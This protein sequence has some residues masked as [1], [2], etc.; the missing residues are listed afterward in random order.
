[1]EDSDAGRPEGGGAPRRRRRNHPGDSRPDQHVPKSSRGNH[2]G[3]TGRRRSGKHRG[4]KGGHRA[5]HFRDFARP[6][7]PRGMEAA[8]QRRGQA[9]RP[10]G[11]CFQRWRGVGRQGPACDTSPASAAPPLD[12]RPPRWR[13]RVE[14]GH[15]VTTSTDSHDNDCQPASDKREHDGT[16]NP[17]RRTTSTDLTARSRKASHTGTGLCRATAPCRAA[18]C[19]RARAAVLSGRPSVGCA[20]ARRVEASA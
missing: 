3:E 16:K 9:P 17:R 15:A 18:R 11:G 13:R 12:R 14:R 8:G 5:E 20:H 6:R 7:H 4:D 2:G 19:Q 1:M 10:A